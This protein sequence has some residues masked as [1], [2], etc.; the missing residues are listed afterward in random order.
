M[1]VFIPEPYYGEVTRPEGT[2]SLLDPAPFAFTGRRT[3]HV[4][5]DAPE[6]REFV[7][8]LEENTVAQ[9]SR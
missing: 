8:L 2:A 5:P 7:R 3:V 4:V 9:E 6:T 1:K